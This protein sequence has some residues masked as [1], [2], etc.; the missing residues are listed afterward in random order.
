VTLLILSVVLLI[1]EVFVLTKQQN[2]LLP[3]NKIY[4]CGIKINSQ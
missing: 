1:L 2:I 3:F 4:N